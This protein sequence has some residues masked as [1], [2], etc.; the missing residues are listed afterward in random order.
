MQTEE[1]FVKETSLRFYSEKEVKINLLLDGLLD[2]LVTDF[3]TSTSFNRLLVPLILTLLNHSL[4]FLKT[5]YSNSQSQT[6]S[7]TLPSS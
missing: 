3:K 5:A 1:E 4:Q 2:Y 7:S 6:S